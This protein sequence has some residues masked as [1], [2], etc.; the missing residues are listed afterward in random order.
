MSEVSVYRAPMRSR[1]DRVP[2]GPA[3]E[4]ALALG[5][6]GVGGRLDATPATLAEALV[7]V[8]ATHGERM[9]RRL[10]RFAAVADGAFV[11]TRDRDGLL[12]LGRLDGPWR[13]D[14][15]PLADVVDLVHVR[16]CRWLRR[17]VAPQ[18]VP[19]AVRTSFARGGRNWQRIR[20]PQA[21]GDSAA[22]WH[23]AADD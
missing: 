16:P 21:S 11:W 17:P 5:L 6:C 9:A 15:R 4:R 2:E 19:A 3:V 13:Y 12:W 20:D 18:E 8:D 10:E 22:L 23:R 14:A 1:D 7:R